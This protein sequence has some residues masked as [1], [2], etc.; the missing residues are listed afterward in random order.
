MAAKPAARVRPHRQHVAAVAHGD[1][2]IG[3][4]ALR[5]RHP[6][7]IRSRSAHDARRRVPR[8]SRRSWPSRALAPSRDGCRRPRGPG[9][10]ASRSAGRS[11]QRVDDRTARGGRHGAHLA[12]VRVERGGGLE[13]AEHRIRI[14]AVD[15]ARRPT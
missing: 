10:S 13:H 9:R 14:R 5:A 6:S 12:A 3:E 1:E 15:A 2:A 8:M 4:H 11:R 7:S